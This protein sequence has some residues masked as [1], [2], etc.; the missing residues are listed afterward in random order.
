[1]KKRFI[2]IC[3]VLLS[4]LLVQTISAQ[5]AKKVIAKAD[6]VPPISY[7]APENLGDL[8]V[9]DAVFQAF[10]MKSRA[11]LEMILRDY[12]VQDKSLWLRFEA[13]LAYLDFLDGK[14]DQTAE[15][16]RRIRETQTPDERLKNGDLFV[17]EALM[18]ASQATGEK[19]GA[20]FEAAFRQTFAAAVNDLPAALRDDVIQ[21]RVFFGD[22]SAEYVVNDLKNFLAP[23]VKQNDGKLPLKYAPNVVG[24]RLERQFFVPLKDDVR[25]IYTSFI[26]SHKPFDFWATREIILT[27]KQKLS[28]V[29]VGV[30]DS[31][32]D[33][34][35]FPNQMFV[36]RREKLNGRDDDGNGIIDDVHGI[37]FDENAR[38]TTDEL[39]PLAAGD[40]PDYLEW[41]RKTK[42]DADIQDG[43]ETAEIIKYKQENAERQKDEAGFN[44]YR[45][46]RRFFSRYAHGTEVA[47]VIV[48][49]NPA[50]RLLIA[51]NTFLAYT[52]GVHPAPTEE[53]ANRIAESYKKTVAY[54][55]AN[56]VRVVN[57]SWMENPQD[58]FDALKLNNIG[59][60]DD[61]RRQIAR[62]LFIITRDA[63]NEAIKSAPEILF[64]CVA[65]NDALDAVEKEYIPASL[66]LPNLLTIGAVDISGAKASFSNTGKTVTLYGYGVNV[67][68][69]APGGKAIRADGT[70]FASPQVAGLAAK[71]L[72]L[73]P[74]LTVAETIALIRQGAEPSATDGKMMIINPKRSVELLSARRKN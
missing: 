34:S 66:D 39:M 11:D 9:S 19:S 21:E 36:N 18:K 68:L 33:A 31:G 27:N 12:D 74:K 72:A 1:M 53:L 37:V 7:D 26:N 4:F 40:Q 23:V 48:K 50:A 64:V 41:T 8:V 5:P 45:E 55:K 16:I 44:K 54:F 59:K 70:S 43:I 67:P 51:R 2:Q 57:M 56:Q 32:V 25:A 38:P 60:D 69:I 17:L 62:K 24:A 10:A 65:G 6:D 28:P 46:Q 14:A 13:T 58:N 15:R 52:T 20:K 63:L 42:F 61:E 22:L 73:D 47:S 71:L 30:W 3:I 29:L 49:G 35:L